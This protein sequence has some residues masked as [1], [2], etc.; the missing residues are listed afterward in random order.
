MG[1][2]FKTGKCTNTTKDIVTFKGKLKTDI[3]EGTMSWYSINLKKS[4]SSEEVYLKRNQ[5][6]HEYNTYASYERFVEYWL[7]VVEPQWSSSK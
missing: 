3:L 5:D 7:K 4:T 6:G 1:F 2:D